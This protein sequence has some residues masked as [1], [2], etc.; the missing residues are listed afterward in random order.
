M[1]ERRTVRDEEILRE[2]LSRIDDSGGDVSQRMLAGELGIALGLVNAYLQRSVADGL[3]AATKGSG[4][5]YRYALTA[6]G[7]AEKIRLGGRHFK[8]SFDLFRHVRD[9]FDRLYAEL[10]ERGVR[11]VALCG[12]DELTEIALLCALDS[13]VTPSGIWRH[14]GRPVDLRGVPGVILSEAIR[15]DMVVV[16]VERN[17]QYVYHALRRRLPP[18][19]IAVPDIIDLRQVPVDRE[20]NGR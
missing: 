3:V 1:T 13:A 7:V 4:R 18:E 15:T 17:V 8:K 9:S 19:R 14:A 2:L 6:K 5:R 10:A 16:S 11:T 20:T 12:I